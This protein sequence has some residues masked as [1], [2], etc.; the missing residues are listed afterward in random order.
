LVLLHRKGFGRSLWGILNCELLKLVWLMGSG[1]KAL[2]EQRKD[3]IAVEELTNAQE[4]SSS[5][6]DS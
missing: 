2:K 1:K 4:K 3:E 5:G 6:L